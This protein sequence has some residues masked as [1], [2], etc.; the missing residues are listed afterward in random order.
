MSP[1]LW[2]LSTILLVL[3][4]IFTVQFI[5]GFHSDQSI[6]STFRP[7]NPNSG[8]LLIVESYTNVNLRV[9]FSISFAGMAG[10]TSEVYLLNGTHY[11]LNNS[12]QVV[13]VNSQVNGGWLSGQGGGGFG[14]VDLNSTGNPLGIAVVGNFSHSDF[15]AQYLHFRVNP[16]N[17]VAIYVTNYSNYY[18]KAVAMPL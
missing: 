2:K 7:S 13:N 9:N 17:Y 14:F 12:H 11:E 5:Q 1:R 15:T 16:A 4:T 6:G 10:G 18:I 3:L 8:T